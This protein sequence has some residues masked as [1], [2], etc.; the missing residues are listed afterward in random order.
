[1]RNQAQAESDVEIATRLYKA[2][3]F[4]ESIPYFEKALSNPAMAGEKSDL[5]TVLGN[6]YNEIDEFEKSLEYHTQAI[7]ADPKNH[8]AYVNKGIVHRLLA[9]YDEAEE[10][11]NQALKLQPDY[12]ELHASLGAL[13][14]YQ[15][16]YEDAIKRLEKSIALD[17]TLP[18]AHSN[19]SIVY[20][21]VGRFDD[22]EKELEKAKALGYHQ[23]EVIRQ[24]IDMLKNSPK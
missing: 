13:Y 12:A 3:K 8:R 1:M 23:P 14:L 7:Q 6:C 22:A 16:K 15:E 2:R 24:R 20:A 17:G 18:V 5:L 21:S 11:Y 10:C 4:K 9:Q 19:L